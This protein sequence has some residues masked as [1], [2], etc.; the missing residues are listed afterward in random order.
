MPPKI[1]DMTSWQQ[2]ERL[3]QPAF[4]RLVDN[5]RKHLEHSAW[6]GTY[7]EVLHWP[8]GTPEETKATVVQLSQQLETATA[9][10]SAA[11]HE[12]LAR[13]P[14]PCPGYQLRLEQQEHR[15][16]VDLWELCYQIC[17]REYNPSQP[18]SQAV[19]IDTSLIDARG[20]VNWD[21]LDQK[22]NQFVAQVFSNLPDV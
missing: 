3:M 18:G 17:F 14:Q 7:T 8:E 4:I 22:A 16:S 6:H 9:E 2:A 15:V 19:E 10:Q 11:I 5:I 13:L 12:T 20:E 21:R 1:P